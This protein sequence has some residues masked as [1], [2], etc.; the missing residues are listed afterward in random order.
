MISKIPCKQKYFCFIVSVFVAD[1]QWA[2][3]WTNGKEQSLWS[4]FCCRVDLRRIFRVSETVAWKICYKR[5]LPSSK[6]PHFQND[7]RCTTFLVKMSFICMRKK[8]D[9][10]IKG[11]APTLV[12]KQK[13]RGTRKWSIRLIVL[14]LTSPTVQNISHQERDNRG[15]F[16]SPGFL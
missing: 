2:D 4:T 3:V 5:P 11:W 1:Q 12:L 8:N 14:Q 13:P 10:H 7:A 6:N 15:P 9:F 16:W